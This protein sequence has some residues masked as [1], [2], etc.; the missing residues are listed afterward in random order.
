M[1]FGVLLWVANC[2]LSVVCYEL[3]VVRPRLL[4]VC[5]SLLWFV[6][7]GRVVMCDVC[8]SLFVVFVVWL[9]FVVCCLSCVAVG[10]LFIARCLLLVVCCLF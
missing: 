10:V 4:I 7:C 8:L 5:A 2:I 9:L 6:V 3:Y 1:L